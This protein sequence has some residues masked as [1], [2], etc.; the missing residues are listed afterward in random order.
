VTHRGIAH[1][2]VVVSG[3]VA[4]DDPRSLADWPMLAKLR[5]TLC[6]LMGLNHLPSIVD[7]L[8]KYGR[9]PDTPVAVVQDGTT[10]AQRVLRGTLDEIA[11]IVAHE[12]VHPPA[13]VVIGD[14]VD[15]L[16]P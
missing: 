14:V 13:V 15:A 4:P 3:H 16:E 12:K 11:D 9:R 8:L 1:E 2:F 7:T 5:G 6:V 10:K